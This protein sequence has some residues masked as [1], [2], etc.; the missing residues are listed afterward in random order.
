MLD[1][2]G[3]RVRGLQ[4]GNPLD[5]GVPIGQLGHENNE[6]RVQEWIRNAAKTGGRLLAG[7]QRRRVFV[8]PAIVAD[9]SPDMC[10]SCNDQLEPAVNLTLFESVDEAIASANDTN[11]G[12][13]AAILAESLDNAMRFA[14]EVD[15]SNIH[16]NW[17]THWQAD[18]MSCGGRKESGLGKG[19]R[20]VR[21]KR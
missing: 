16:I 7:S 17:G 2:L 10:I 20:A 12:L 19:A 14:R 6:I 11:P 13:S 4:T 5:D 3:A 15:S 1:N 8:E 21:P 18:V 9:V